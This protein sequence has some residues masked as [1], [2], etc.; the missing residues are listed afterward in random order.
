M[1][2]LT[3]RALLQ[4]ALLLSAVPAQYLIA[5]WSGVTAAQRF[6]AT[7]RLLRM[8]KEWQASYLS[9]RV[10]TEWAEQQLSK[11]TSLAGFAQEDGESGMKPPT[12]NMILE[13]DQGFFGA[14]KTVRSPRPPFV[15]LRVGQVVMEKRSSRVGVVVSWDPEMRAP[16][17]WVNRMYT[18]E[19]PSV[20]TPHYKVLF[21]GPGPS[22]LLV[23]Y[24]PQT[25]LVGI[26]GMMPE[27]PTLEDYFS[28]FDGK[29][30]VLQPWLRKI[31]PE[32]EAES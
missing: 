31:Y 21:S 29:R 30:F 2:Q 16:T 22:S 15:F 3:A 26:T 25:Q 23:A 32:D 6:H 14:S 9:S 17:D 27:I 10:W 28:H 4:V 13:N 18:D 11:V 7:S 19:R 5:H 20:R 12:E 8:W 24:L 1:P